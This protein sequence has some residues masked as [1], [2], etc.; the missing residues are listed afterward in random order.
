MSVS[1]VVTCRE[2]QGER[3]CLSPLTCACAR[4]HVCTHVST[5]AP[6]TPSRCFPAWTECFHTSRCDVR[7][8]LARSGL[9]RRH[10]RWPAVRGGIWPLPGPHLWG[11][12]LH[13]H[14]QAADR[15]FISP[16]C[17][18]CLSGLD[19]AGT[20]CPL[21]VPSPRQWRAAIAASAHRAAPARSM[22]KE[23]IH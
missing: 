11:V 13:A 4:P 1:S 22:G 20:P 12:C 9:Q 5:H 16:A 6:H 2:W 3:P 19:S 14:E 18:F 15:R 17:G 10:P 8:C 7:F 21:L 23:D